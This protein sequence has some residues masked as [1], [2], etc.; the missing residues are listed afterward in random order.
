M[1]TLC[2]LKHFNKYKVFLEKTISE[3]ALLEVKAILNY[4]YKSLKLSKSE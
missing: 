3:V 2:K 1:H 4:N